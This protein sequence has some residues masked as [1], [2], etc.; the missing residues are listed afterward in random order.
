[1]RKHT[2]SVEGFIPRQSGSNLGDLHSPGKQQAAKKTPSRQIKTDGET[3]LSKDTVGQPRKG[4]LI[5]RDDIDESL[6]EIDDGSFEDSKKSRK[7]RKKDLKGKKPKR[8][9]RR[10]IFWVLMT[11]LVAGLAVGGYLVYKAITATESVFQGSVFDIVK[12]D[13]LKTDANGRSNFLVF[14]T[15]EDD[16]GGTHGGANLTDS[17]MVISVDQEE[18]NAYMVSLPRDL[19]VAYQ[20]TCTVGNQGKLNAVY[21]CASDDGA[22]ETAGAQALMA[23]AGEI[24][25]LDIQYY[26]HLNFTAVVDAVNAV[27]GV[28]VTINSS[29]PRGILDRNFDWKCGY[30]CYYVNYQNGEE[31]HLDGEHALALARARNAAG[32]YGLPNGNFDREQNQQMII[33]ALRDK[34]LS[35]GTLTNVSAVTGLIDALGNNLRT[36]I[37]TK[38][39]R[40][41]MDIASNTEDTD[42]VSLSLVEEGT[43]L[44]TTGSYNGQSIVRPVAGLLDYSAIQEFVYINVSADPFVREEP[45]VSVFNGS[46]V[47]GVAQNAAYELEDAGFTVAEVDNAPEGSYQTVEI[48]QLN[49][50]KTASAEKLEDLYGVKVKTTVPPVA[51]VGDTDFVVIIGNAGAV[52]E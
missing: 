12:N 20:E 50:E 8:R 52:Q 5:G 22:D 51:V 45:V 28:D 21:F 39:V 31:V 40:T 36:N 32:G 41:L 10:I 11:L 23:K 44:V 26:V 29:D 24:T 1:M 48:Y 16:E 43:M 33:K 15:A 27:G 2:S 35:A 38:E 49:S 14:G 30:T 19:W 9:A 3:V 37:E 47:A 17:I 7:E 18:H 6:R 34:A 25:G 13:P 46:G 4:R 42:I